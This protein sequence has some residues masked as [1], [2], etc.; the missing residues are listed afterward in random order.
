MLNMNHLL[1]ITLKT[2]RNFI[3]SLM[4]SELEIVMYQ[5]L[6][7][8]SKKGAVAFAD[9]DDTPTGKPLI[10]SRELDIHSGSWRYGARCG[11]FCFTAAGSWLVQNQITEHPTMHDLARLKNSQLAYS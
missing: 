5:Y 9:K 8:K 1:T 3:N 6:R 2:C 4:K 11:E 10:M 7:K